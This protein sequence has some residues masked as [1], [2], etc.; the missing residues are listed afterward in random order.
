MVNYIDRVV[1]RLDEELW[2]CPVELINYYALLV[3]TTG[4]LTTL[5]DVHDAW[6]IWTNETLWTH[7]S[8]IPFNELTLEV[9][10]LDQPYRDAIVKIA[11][12][13]ADE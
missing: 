5:E 7:K 9:Q 6:S 8:L 4:E 3:L 13:L 1:T 10:E 2:G 12:E 11:K